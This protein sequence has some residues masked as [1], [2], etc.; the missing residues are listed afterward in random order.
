MGA[1]AETSWILTFEDDFNGTALN[2]STWNSAQNWTHCSPCEPQLYETSRLQVA[3]GSLEITTQRDHVLGPGGQLFN[4]SSGWIDTE[5][6]FAQKYGKFEAR[7]RLPP[8]NAAGIWPAFWLMPLN[9]ACWP[10]GGEVDIFEYTA[11]FLV[12]NVFGSYRWGTSC[13]VDNQPL[14]GAA[15]PPTGDIDWAA[16]YHTFG[17]EWNATAITFFV[18][19]NAYDTRTNATVNLPTTPMYIIINSA[20]AYYW[21][22]DASASYPA[23]MAVDWVRVWAAAGAG[24]D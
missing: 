13:G 7:M 4:F 6:K 1:V 19:G 17:V 14:P 22:P 2:T 11:N 8:Q 9:G 16:D 18:D 20:I 24:E 15:Y 3:N 23:T 12:N 5:N 21:M 10:V